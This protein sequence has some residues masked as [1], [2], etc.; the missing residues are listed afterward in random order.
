[1]AKIS[2]DQVEFNQLY[3]SVGQPGTVFGTSMDHSIK[4]P[5]ARI[6]SLTGGPSDASSVGASYSLQAFCNR[7]SC[8]ANEYVTVSL[9][10]TS[11]VVVPFDVDLSSDLIMTLNGVPWGFSYTKSWVNNSATIQFR[12]PD[13]A[14]LYKI[15]F[16]TA[17]E[18]QTSTAVATIRVSS[19]LLND[20]VLTSLTKLFLDSQDVTVIC[21]TAQSRGTGLP[22][23]TFGNN[24]SL[25]TAQVVNIVPPVSNDMQ[26]VS[27]AGP[28]PPSLPLVDPWFS[29][30]LD[31]SCTNFE[32]ITAEVAFK[33]ALG[34]P[35]WRMP[36]SLPANQTS[37]SMTFPFPDWEDQYTLLLGLIKDVGWVEGTFELTFD[38]SHGLGF[39]VTVSK[40]SVSAADSSNQPISFTNLDTNTPID[41]LFPIVWVQGSTYLV[42]WADEDI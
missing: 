42:F 21:V 35:Q 34:V 33:D 25:T 7:S 13:T 24:S 2:A 29:F 32:G 12:S 28:T 39:P 30:S 6:N 11:K 17:F 4:S 37:I 16:T 38:H 9:I 20:F 10:A 15:A 40:F 1:V 36:V 23:T 8:Y 14:G 26:V 27:L 19:S 41:A 22:I 18:I 3:N 5:F 31:A